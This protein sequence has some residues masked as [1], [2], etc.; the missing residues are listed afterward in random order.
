VQRSSKRTIVAIVLGVALVVALGAFAISGDIGEPEV[1]DG[2]VAIVEDAPDGGITDE[3]FQTALEQSAFNLQLKDVPPQ[4]DP[5]YEQVSQ[6][7]ISNAIQTRWVKGEAEERGISVDERDVD[8]ALDSII[9]EQLGGQKGYEK[10]L[11]DSPFDE[12]AVRDVAE[13]T[14]ISDRLQQDAIPQDKPPEVSDA[15]VEDYYNT[16]VEQFQTPETRDVRVIL[17][18]D[19]AKINDAIDELGSDPT[20]EDWKRVAQKYSTDDA[21]KN[22]GG[23]R[24]D[25]AQGQ[26]EPALDEAIFSAAQGEIVGPITGDSGSYVIQVEG[27]TPESTSPLD[28]VSDQIR[29]TLQQGAQSLQVENFRTD[30]IDKWTARTFCAEDVMVD[31]CGNA[32]PAP[33]ACTVDDDS[34]R[35]QAE[36]TALDAGCPAPVPPRSVVNPG[37]GQVFPGEQIPAL[38][39][40]PI[41][42]QQ[43]QAAPTGLPPGAAPIGPGGAPTPPSGAAPP[44]G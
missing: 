11:Q 26:N 35:E 24:E 43:P 13:L 16:H 40:G 30:F 7:A 41:K 5:Q 3:E 44:G 38:P 36:P 34:E 10:F 29:Q 37:T 25:V 6:A 27:I 39:Q 23:L 19:E 1:P 14:A 9:Q 31:L 32:P 2:D 21:T 28:E 8:Q 42:Q 17:N 4:D 18:P 20:P 12:E 33:D 22:D 15:E